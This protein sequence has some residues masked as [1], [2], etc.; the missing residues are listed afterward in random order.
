[1]NRILFYQHE[2]DSWQG[3]ESHANIDHTT[4]TLYCTIPIK[5]FR[6]LHIITILR[7]KVGDSFKCGIINSTL[8][9]LQLIAYTT[10]GIEVC[11]IQDSVDANIVE[12]SLEGNKSNFCHV[13]S[14]IAH[15]RPPVMTRILKDLTSMGISGMYVYRAELSEK[16]YMQSSLWQKKDNII[17]EGA[18]QGGSYN[19]PFIDRAYSLKEALQKVAMHTHD[20]G[21]PC[22]THEGSVLKLT[23]DGTGTHNFYSCV[24]QFID[25][26]TSSVANNG[27]N[28]NK[29]IISV[30]GPERGFTE[31]EYNMLLEYNYIPTVLSNRILRS[32]TAVT[33]ANGYIMGYKPL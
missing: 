14:V 23:C 28:H 3:I 10:T 9:T 21:I 32:E 17:L 27:D 4:N 26:K 6:A 8:A 20:S 30:I 1:M 2:I 12:R 31:D 13:Y 7:G 25:A 16:S 19:V 24:Q 22:S 29:S 18:M 15:V 11:I 33:L 5:D